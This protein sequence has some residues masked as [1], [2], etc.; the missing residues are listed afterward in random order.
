MTLLSLMWGC[1][2]SE[3]DNDK[4]LTSGSESRRSQAM[5]L[6]DDWEIAGIDHNR[7][8][9]FL[10]KWLETNY[11][12]TWSLS[13]LQLQVRYA[14]EE[15]MEDSTSYDLTIA[16][17]AMDRVA[18]MEISFNYLS[19]CVD[20]LITNEYVSA[21]EE[22]Y[23][24]RLLSF[25]YKDSLSTYSF[26][27]SLDLFVGDVKCVEWK[28]D[29]ILC[30]AFAAVLVYSWDYQVAGGWNFNPDP[31][32]PIF[33]NG[34]RT[35]AA[36]LAGA[37]AGGLIGAAGGGAGALPGAVGGGLGASAADCVLQM[38]GF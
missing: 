22:T 27:D 10:D 25:V 7:G 35:G 16:K 6:D 12:S 33:W 2:F 32:D 3:S 1:Q 5:N 23:I 19:A 14:A 18:V 21:L 15:F 26:Q 17:S 13:T 31:N 8:M 24:R 11:D 20:T 36:D 4:I 37:V 38:C 30:L 34:R 29:E 9:V 28:E